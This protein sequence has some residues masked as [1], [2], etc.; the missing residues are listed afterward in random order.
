VAA[1]LGIS[2]PVSGVILKARVFTSGPRDDPIEEDEDVVKIETAALA[3]LDS[4]ET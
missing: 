3:E 1:Q 2:S 4:T